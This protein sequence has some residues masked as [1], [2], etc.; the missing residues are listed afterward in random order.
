MEL[1]NGLHPEPLGKEGFQD[2][3][4]EFHSPHPPSS[5]FPSA[6]CYAKQGEHTLDTLKGRRKLDFI[7]EIEQWG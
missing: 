2:V 5:N 7:E 1:V 4:G 3:G 6:A